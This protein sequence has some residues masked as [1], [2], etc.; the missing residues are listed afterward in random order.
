MAD[1]LNSLEKAHIVE[2]KNL[3]SPQKL[4]LTLGDCLCIIFNIEPSWKNAS[5]M[6]SRTDFL[7]NLLNYD[8]DNMPRERIEKLRPIL[9]NPEFNYDSVKKASLAASYLYKYVYGLYLY[10]NKKYN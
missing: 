5:M 8:K 7:S 4:I 6:L 9:T 3:K 10:G 2:L 1:A